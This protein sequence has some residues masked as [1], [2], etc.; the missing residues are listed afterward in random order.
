MPLMWPMHAV[1]G[2]LLIT[3][4]NVEDVA[5]NSAWQVPSVY[6]GS[7]LRYGDLLLVIASQR[8]KNAGIVHQSPTW[9]LHA[10]TQRVLYFH[11]ASDVAWLWRP[12]L[13]AVAHRQKA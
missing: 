4:E 7:E 12:D 13:T 9:A 11:D 10:R 5:H 8:I 2:E 6:N 3:T 1:P